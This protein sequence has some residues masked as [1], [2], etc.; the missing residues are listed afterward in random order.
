VI[1]IHI[2]I[3]E[4]ST[5]VCLGITPSNKDEEAIL[6]NAQI[7]ETKNI[8]TFWGDTEVDGNPKMGLRINLTTKGGLKMKQKKKKT[9]RGIK[10]AEV[11]K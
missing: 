11:K 6:R 9:L 8:L 4:Y 2:N 5:L 1:Q 7:E 3:T 10:A